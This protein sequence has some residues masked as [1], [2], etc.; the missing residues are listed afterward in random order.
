MNWI[1]RIL[2]KRTKSC[3]IQNVSPRYESIVLDEGSGEA[4]HMWHN[5][6]KHPLDHNWIIW[7][8]IARCSGCGR[9]V[10]RRLVNED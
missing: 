5:K 4:I 8:N 1:K 9:K 3:A 10:E 6:N 2:Q 7:D